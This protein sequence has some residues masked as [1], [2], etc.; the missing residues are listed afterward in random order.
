ETKK[1]HIDTLNIR[2]PLNISQF[3]RSKLH[4]KF[5]KCN[6]TIQ[7]QFQRINIIDPSKQSLNVKFQAKAANLLLTVTKALNFINVPFWLSSGTCLGWYRQCE[8]F[9]NSKDVDI[10]VFIKDFKPLVIQAL[11][12]EGLTLALSLGKVK[13]TDG[14]ELVFY[15]DKVKLDVFFFYEE[16][17]CMWN[18][19]TDVNTGT[20]YKYIFNKFT[21][22]WTIFMNMFLRVPCET[23]TYIQNNYGTDWIR[24]VNEWDWKRSPSNVIEAGKWPKDEWNQVMIKYI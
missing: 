3:I 23:N 20:K 9:E 13:P 8:L 19:G 4:S 11:Q 17:D 21:L 2:I 1:V 6:E 18:G 22:C 10:G 16:D 14:Y 15:N 24:L 12:M 5:I 7:K